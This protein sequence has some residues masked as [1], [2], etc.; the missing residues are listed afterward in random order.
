[1]F[2]TRYQRNASLPPTVA[3]IGCVASI[4]GFS[5]RALYDRLRGDGVPVVKGPKR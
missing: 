2:L 3:A 5:P 1:M 4:G